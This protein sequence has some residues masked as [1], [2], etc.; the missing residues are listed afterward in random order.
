MIVEIIP[1]AYDAIGKI[2]VAPTTRNTKWMFSSSFPMLRYVNQP[3]DMQCKTLSDVR[4]FLRKCRYISDYEQFGKIDYW[5][6]PDE[7]EKTKKGDCEDYALWAWRQMMYLGYKSRYVVGYSGKYGEGHAW[8][9][10]EKEG[11]YYVVEALASSLGEKLPRLRGIYY[12]PEMSVEYDG[13]R[14]KFYKHQETNFNS[15]IRIAVSLAVE[16]VL[17]W[18]WFWCKIIL[19]IIFLPLIIL[20]NLFRRFILKKGSI[21][22]TAL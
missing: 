20:R 18:V 9:T 12:K 3:L 5:L 13:D 2:C 7:F 6:P 4:K 17:F 22:G 11:K 21:K 19:I 10:I 16:W 1:E 15:S 14:F 8:V